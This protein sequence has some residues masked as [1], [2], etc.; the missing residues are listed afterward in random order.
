MS[1]VN[2]RN[3]GRYSGV[4]LGKGSADLGEGEEKRKKKGL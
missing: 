4:E 2:I 3:I 1:P